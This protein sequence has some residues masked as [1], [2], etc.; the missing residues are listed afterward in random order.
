MEN[1]VSNNSSP[2]GKKII[3]IVVL[4]V[5]ALLV[6]GGYFMIKG[7]NSPFS[8][9]NFFGS[10][11]KKIPDT[12]Y[13][14]IGRVTV[15]AEDK[16]SFNIKALSGQNYVIEDTELKALVHYNT[17]TK[18]ASGET[19]TIVDLSV[20]D[21]VAIISKANT[22]GKNEFFIDRIVT[23]IPNDSNIED[24]MFK[25]FEKFNV[26][27]SSGEEVNPVNNPVVIPDEVTGY[28]G[29]IVAI[30]NEAKEFYIFVEKRRNYVGAD[31][32]FLVKTSD[33]TRFSEYRTYADKTSVVNEIEFNDLA[34]S[35]TATIVSG[36]NIVN[37]EEFGVIRV[38]RSIEE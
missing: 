18:S 17:E 35:D 20:G 3:W 2:T 19:L 37:M 8:S 29:E 10:S 32:Y 36:E 12:V 22:K 34:V 28:V 14:Y 13:T 15:I 6:I 27:N 5:V 30:N 24:E 4:V 31:S 21:F 16:S 23:D 11:G 25:E 26:T 9:S 33:I 38:T 1:N 7:D